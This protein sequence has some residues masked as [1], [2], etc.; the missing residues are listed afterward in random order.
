MNRPPSHRPAR[1]SRRR[2]QG[3]AVLAVTL[4][5]LFA[6]SLAL[7]YVNRAQ[8]FDQ[9]ASA[10][11]MH[12][13]TAI[14]AAE[15]GIEWATGMLNSP[16]DIGTDCTFESTANVSFRKRYV[17]TQ[18]NA[19]TNPTSDIV[20]A[21]GVLPGCRITAAGLA[22]NCPA[23][24][25]GTAALGTASTP[26]FTVKFETITG[27]TEAVRVTSWGCTAHD[28]AC[29]ATSAANADA[30]ARVQVVLKLKPVL[31]AAP[32][33]PLTCGTSCQVGGSASIENTNAPTNGILINAGT[34]ISTAPG[35]SL[36]T[37]PGMPA[38]NALV[39]NDASLSALSSTD[40]TCDNS[41]MFRAFFGSGI[42]EYRRAPTTRV[43]SCSSASDCRSQLTG[44]YDDGWRSFYFS[45]DLHLSGNLSIGSSADPVTLVTPNAIDINGTM[46]IYG[47]VFS[48]SADWNDLGT[49]SATIHGAQVSC[50]AY[51]NNGNGTLSYDADAL[52]NA[53]NYTARMVRVPGSWKDF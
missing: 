44:A 3:V 38:G 15:A 45:S 16:F 23:P 34:T 7:L 41:N 4:L 28:T 37:L 20:V 29:S 33:S 17:M 21:A 40:P 19:A 2:H 49:G 42:E 32:A 46:D 47:L 24:G 13:T 52:R 50:A 30:N 8:L 25:A 27:D 10:N 9:R 39:G 18:W 35:V 48:N 31:R 26:S 5:L 14:E 51:R 36:S 22:C 53:R 11:L 43:L 6:T 12:S 1:N